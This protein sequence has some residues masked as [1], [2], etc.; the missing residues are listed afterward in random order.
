[1]AELTPEIKQLIKQKVESEM[2]GYPIT[3]PADHF[4]ALKES[5]IKSLESAWI[6]NEITEEDL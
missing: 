4:K 6:N 2:T 1:M 5:N 3:I